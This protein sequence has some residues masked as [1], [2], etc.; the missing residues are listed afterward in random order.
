VSVKYKILDPEGVYF[1][2]YATTGWI[3]VFTRE[4]YCNIALESLA[5]CQE[6]KGLILHAWCIMPSHIHLLASTKIP[7]NK[8]EKILQ[9]TKKFTAREI[10]KAIEENRLESRKEWMLKQ[11][12]QSGKAGI[13]QFWQHDNHPIET[14]SNE[15]IQQKIDYIHNNPVEAGIVDEPW[16]YRYSSS[17]DYAGIKGLLKV[18]ML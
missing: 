15:I 18:E 12:K 13:N 9:D 3:D 17:R 11:F 8:L 1:V 2:S 7:E 16:H 14:Y 4:T 10:I 5:Y 6:K